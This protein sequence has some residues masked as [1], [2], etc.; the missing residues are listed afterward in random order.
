MHARA[1]AARILSVEAA[2]VRFGGL[3][4]TVRAKPQTSGMSGNVFRVSET[5]SGKHVCVRL[6]DAWRED[7]EHGQADRHHEMVSNTIAVSEAGLGP[8]VLGFDDATLVTEWSSG[9]QLS[10]DDFNTPEGAAR[11]GVFFAKLHSI[12]VSGQPERM[13][14]RVKDLA[15]MGDHVGLDTTLLKLVLRLSILPE[16][17]PLPSLVWTHG[18]LHLENVLVGADSSF[19]VIDNE[20]AG[21][22]PAAGDLAY[23]MVTWSMHLGDS[24]PPYALR[25]ALAEAYLREMNNMQQTTSELLWELEREAPFQAAFC[26]MAGLMGP[27]DHMW[28]EAMKTCL[29]AV[30][31]S[32]DVLANVQWQQRF[33]LAERALFQDGVFSVPPLLVHAGRGRSKI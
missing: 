18:D 27:S 26:A 15:A 30:A 5:A 32:V 8:A 4:G 9:R 11:L 17:E 1:Q 23:F 6:A 25:H 33:G 20:L 10:L 28:S 16:P 24:Y 3:Q 14:A 31:E 22:R 7:A 2:A 12:P 19:S 21:A 29:H 13:K